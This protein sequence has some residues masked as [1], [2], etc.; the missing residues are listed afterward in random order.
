MVLG[1]FLMPQKSRA[2][3]ALSYTDTTLCP[4]ETIEMCAALL[5]QTSTLNSDDNFSEIVPIGFPFNFFGNT[6]TKIVAS[7]NGFIT[8]DTTLASPVNGPW[9]YGQTPTQERNSIFAA[10]ADWYLPNGGEIR[11]Q[12][13]GSPGSRKFIIEWCNIPAF[14]S[15][16]CATQKV[17]TQLIL[18][19]TTNVIEIH[20]TQLPILSGGCPTASP[21]NRVVQGVKNATGTATFFTTNR[22][23]SGPL[24]ANWG[25]TGI[26]NDA[27]RYSP[28]TN[29]TG[30]FIYNIDSIPYSPFIILDSL[31]S[32]ILKWYDPLQ[33]TS[34]VATGSC[35]TVTP[36]GSQDYYLVAFNGYG[37]C[38]NTLVDIV[39]TVFIHYGSKYD[40]LDVNICQG[41]TYNFHGR[42][43]DHSGVFDTSFINTGGCDSFIH[44]DLH[45]N[46]LPIPTLT[47]TNAN[48]FFC[49]G[50]AATLSI[51]QPSPNYSYQWKRN[52][53]N[54]QGGS[55]ASLTT[56]NSGDYQ[57]FVTTVKGCKDSSTVVHLEKDTVA[58]DFDIL[59]LPGCSSDTIQIVN[60][61]EP[62]TYEWNFGDGSYPPDTTRN[63][64]HIYAQQGTYT[65]Q[66]IMQ[67]TLSCKDSLMRIVDLNHP[68]EAAFTV[69]KDSVCQDDGTV[70]H[71]TDQSIGASDYQWSFG[72]G[73]VAGGLIR[74]PTHQYS[75]AGNL[76]ARLVIS[77]TLGCHDTAIQ[78]I[79]VD[80]IP[81]LH[82]LSNKTEICTGEQL[83]LHLNY[84]SETAQETHWELGD[85]VNW[86]DTKEE[87]TH[88]YDQSGAYSV[89]ATV[90]YPVC[91]STSDT[92]LITVYDLPQ[93][94]LGND[95]VL[96]LQGEPILLK[97]L[98]DNPSPLTEYLW[99]TGDTTTTLSVVHP[100]TYSLTAT[101]SDCS[102]TESVTIEKDCYTDVPNAFTPNG[103]GNNDYFFPRQYLSSGV[104]ALT[105]SIYNRWGQ[106]V[107]ET[108]KTDGRGWDGRFNGE[109]QPS[110]VYIYQ[111]NL[112]YHNG[113]TEKYSGNVTLL[114]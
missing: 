31:Y 75:L 33:P 12:H 32:S 46:P 81:F 34:P 94:N 16:V 63:P 39:D 67:D 89:I 85:G 95:S 23:P 112:I 98:A 30:G 50:A 13:F 29:A 103:D 3:I 10:F 105:L 4:G 40:T 86:E 6:Y 25:N 48:Q 110:G 65:V 5:G 111:I 38:L 7:G 83:Q 44:L 101:I 66:L 100:G 62:G 60:H 22:D 64:R 61:S 79:Y 78:N 19:E 57:L 90:D 99:S 77:D 41:D 87:A 17:V 113:R 56:T 21:N 73:D 2:Q 70:V 74:N 96:C 93:V 27:R 8:F 51:A 107:F 45:V 28:D 43:L 26:T 68:L 35:A 49:R 20:T 42:I 37:G 47:D 114:R 82:L 9:Y 52:G 80:S 24:A 106:K 1:V 18:Y 97:N 92:L 58:I 108:N 88:G 14:L 55:N 84:L 54:A 76:T 53:Q 15:G 36:D 71:F 104:N 109:P 59:P 72:D 69:D 91:P 102:T 11:Y